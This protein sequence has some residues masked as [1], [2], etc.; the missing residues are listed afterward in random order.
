M[1]DERRTSN[2]EHR[3]L[4]GKAGDGTGMDGMGEVEESTSWFFR[5]LSILSIPVPVSERRGTLRLP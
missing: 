2:A 1:K 4:N 3:I 5:I